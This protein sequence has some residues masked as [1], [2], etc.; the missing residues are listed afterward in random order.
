MTSTTTQVL[1]QEEYRYDA[2]R[3]DRPLQ[4][5]TDLKEGECVHLETRI[6]PYSDPNLSIEWFKDNLPLRASNRLRTISEFGIVILEIS[7]VQAEDSGVY[8]LRASNNYGEAVLSSIIRCESSRN[9]LYESQIL[10]NAALYDQKDLVDYRLQ[11]QPRFLDRLSD[12]KIKENELVHLESRL[13]PIGDATM[14]VEWFIDGKPFTT[15]SRFRT[16]SDF[17][18]VVLEIIEAYAR[19]SG[20]YEC[21]ASNQFGQ[22]SI[23]CRVNIE[24]AK[25]IITDT[26]LPL[27]Y[28]E[29]IQILEERI[30]RPYVRPQESEIILP[31]PTFTGKIESVINKNE[32]ESIHL[33]CRVEPH[34]DV[35]LQIEWFHNGRPLTTGSRIHTVNDFGFVVLDID[36]LFARD[37]GQYKCVATNRSGYDSFEVQLNVKAKSNIILDSQLQ[38]RSG[39]YITREFTVPR[40]VVPLQDNIVVNENESIHFETRIEPVGDGELFIE[41]YHNNQPLKSGHRHK[42]IFDFGFLSLDI[43]SVNQEDSGT[44]TCVA[45]SP[46]GQD[47]ISSNVEVKTKPKLDFTSQ[48]PKEMSGAIEKIAEIEAFEKPEEP[49][50]SKN[51]NAAPQV[52]Q[53]VEPLVVL[54]GE[55][56]RFSCRIIG[57]PKPRVMWLLN[58]STIVHGSRYKIKYDGIYQLEIPKTRQYDS[59]KIEVYAKNAFGEAYTSTTLEVRPRNADYRAILKH[60]P[61]SMSFSSYNSAMLS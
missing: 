18:Y 61:R 14:K 28:T 9:V 16:I 45:K 51:V 2:P 22:D 12:I 44:Y 37:S 60:S 15:G 1:T 42:T 30:T 4:D 38:A 17:G 21:R 10:Q 41:W 29:N 48:L 27:E 20:V 31:K 8:T 23:T 19:D 36:W 34:N 55:V 39:E 25:T 59:G 56:A 32:S 24:A 13:V 57:F 6:S 47:I 3:F 26:Q 49:T 46:K 7:P 11:Q 5:V 40:F 52:V 43:I 33:E 35:D 58:D 53:N 50:E 54:E